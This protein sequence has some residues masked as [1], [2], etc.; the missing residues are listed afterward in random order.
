VLRGE[1]SDLLS[2]ETARRMGETVPDA[3]I[4]TVPATGHT[5][6]L[7]EPE[8]LA[9]LDRLLARVLQTHSAPE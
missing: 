1:L 8:S 2:V 5:P 3:D 9:A 7:E 6:N 4:V